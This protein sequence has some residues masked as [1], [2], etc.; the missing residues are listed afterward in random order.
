MLVLNYALSAASEA[1]A[2]GL[3]RNSER[4]KKS[5]NVNVRVNY[6]QIF[7]K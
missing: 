1:Q 7:S 4:L 5:L 6:R 3:P 2:V